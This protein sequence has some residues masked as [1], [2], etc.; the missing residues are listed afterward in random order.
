M[1]KEQIPLTGCSTGKYL[2]AYI[3]ECHRTRLN[4]L[5]CFGPMHYK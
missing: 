1:M 4:S 3:D 5:L 2:V